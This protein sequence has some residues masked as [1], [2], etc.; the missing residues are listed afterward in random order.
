MNE[1]IP[2]LLEPLSVIGEILIYLQV[3]KYSRVCVASVSSH[4]NSTTDCVVLVQLDLPVVY[5]NVEKWKMS[6]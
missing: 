5:N 1:L 4:T 6:E 3:W 2:I